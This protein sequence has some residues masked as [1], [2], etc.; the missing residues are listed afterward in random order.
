MKKYCLLKYVSGNFYI[1]E[2]V[3]RSY[4]CREQ[5]IIKDP[6][7]GLLKISSSC[8]ITSSKGINVFEGEYESIEEFKK[9]CTIGLL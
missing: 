9:D 8:E 7:A 1:A 3:K 4:V 6:H 5:Y 2:I